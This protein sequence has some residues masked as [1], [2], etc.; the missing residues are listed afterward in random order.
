MPIAQHE[1]AWLCLCLLEDVDSGYRWNLP[2]R[3][4]NLDQQRLGDKVSQSEL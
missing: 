3:R 1:A 2:N 4:W